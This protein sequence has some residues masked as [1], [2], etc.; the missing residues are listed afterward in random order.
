[1]RMSL[2]L[3]IALGCGGQEAAVPDVGP[4]PGVEPAPPVLRRLTE[5]QYRASVTALL[6]PGLA[7]P[8]ALEPDVEVD[9]LLAVGA[10]EVAVSALGVERYEAA[11][12]LLADQADP[13]ALL[14][15]TPAGDAD[16][17]CARAFVQVVGRR[18][19]R[20]PLTE[21]EVGRLADVVTTIGTAQ[22]DFDAGVRYALAAMLQSPYFLY[23]VETSHDGPLTGFE[24][25]TRLA[26]LLWAQPPDDGLLDRAAAG[27]LDTPKGVREVA[28]DM[29]DDPRAEQGVR[30]FADDWLHLYLLDD[31]SKD[32]M[33]FEHASPELAASAREETLALFTRFALGN[34]DVRDVLTTSDAYVDPRLAALYRLPSPA[35]QGFAWTELPKDGRRRGLLGNASVLNIGSH[36][37]RSSA[38]LRG[39]FVRTFLLCHEIPEPPADVD[40]SLPEPDATAPTLRDRVAVHLEEPACA[41]CHQVTDPIG[42][43]LE[44]FDA[45]GRWRDTE[46][47]VTIDASG[48]LDGEDF[49]N[50]WLLADVL[51]DHEDVVHC[52]T[53]RLY[54]YGTGQTPEAG[55]AEL[56]DWL[57]ASLA[58][59]DHRWRELLLAFVISDG[60][61]TVGAQ[62]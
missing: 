22:G 5:S 55:Q 29:L 50:A 51:H 4:A 31:L 11:S 47:G 46:N 39:K 43:A 53:D 42:L 54:A 12:F 9:G 38:T 35:L 62:P 49:A 13:A 32:P 17:D 6:G 23:R 2:L 37:T 24:V 41:A 52:W 44:N 8:T 18:A 14:P 19:W 3:L 20:R 56:V 40:T 59:S 28:S 15:C 34:E 30:A 33:L 1:M 16:G 25:A 58:A 7:M 61:L 36:A 27:D 45:T 26:Y 60:F 10:S 48:T 57:S 21:D